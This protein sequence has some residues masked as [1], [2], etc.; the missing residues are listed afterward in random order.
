[1]RRGPGRDARRHM[2]SWRTAAA[3]LLLVAALFGVVPDAGALDAAASFV[4]LQRG[5]EVGSVTSS[6]IR[7]GDGPT[8]GFGAATGAAAGSASSAS[9]LRFLAIGG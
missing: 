7:T 2:A 8:T 5:A 9:F 4:I 3:L 6:V 1:M